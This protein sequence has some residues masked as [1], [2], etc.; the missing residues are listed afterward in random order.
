MDA[1]EYESTEFYSYK[2]KNFSTIIIIPAAILVLL[3]FIGS[4]FA[5]RQS[6]VS[7]IG[8]VEPTVVI[9]QKNANYDEGQIIT[10]HGQKWIAHVNQNSGVSLMP[11]MKAKGKVRIVTYVPTNKI[12]S[13]KKGQKLNFS[14]PTGEGLTSRL[15]GKVEGIGVYPINVNKQSMYE[16]ISIAKVS[17]I[18]VKYG[19]Q[20]NATIVT[21]HSTYFK[22]FLDK[23]LNK[24]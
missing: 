7:S 10:K 1:K 17:D 13:I 23:V 21:G 2:F 8:I 9:K 6:T 19:M 22:Y 5:V 3:L 11:M 12:S 20:G 24:R 4:F 18:N 14:V 15:T 16:V